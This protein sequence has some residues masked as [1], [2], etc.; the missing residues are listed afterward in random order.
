MSRQITLCILLL[1]FLVPAL[2]Q[3][4]QAASKLDMLIQELQIIV[5]RLEKKEIDEIQNELERLKQNIQLAREIKL[6]VVQSQQVVESRGSELTQKLKEDIRIFY[7][8]LREIPIIRRSDEWGRLES[9]WLNLQSR[10]VDS[11]PESEAALYQQQIK[12]V[13]DELH[14]LELA[15]EK[16][17]SK[18]LQD[19]YQLYLTVSKDNW[20]QQFSRWQAVQSS[21]EKSWEKRE[22]KGLAGAAHFEEIYLALLDLAAKAREQKEKAHK[23]FAAVYGEVQNL[24]TTLVKAAIVTR[25]EKWI[26]YEQKWR[27]IRDADLTLLSPQETRKL[28][29]ELVTLR[30]ALLAYQAEMQQLVTR[31][32][33]SAQGIANNIRHDPWAQAVPSYATTIAQ[34]DAQWLSLLDIP[35][36]KAVEL[37]SLLGGF[38]DMQKNAQ[39]SCKEMQ[40]K[41]ASCKQN[42]EKWTVL[43]EPNSLVKRQARWFQ[44]QSQWQELRHFRLENATPAASAKH[45][46]RLSEIQATLQDLQ[47]ETQK[48]MT[49]LLQKAHNIYQN[50]AQETWNST[51]RQWPELAKEW[52]S[53][54]EWKK[55]LA[56]SEIAGLE[57][58]LQKMQV[59]QNT[60]RQQ[61]E[62]MLKEAH[63]QF[64]E[65]QK[66]FEAIRPI[67]NKEANWLEIKKMWDSLSTEQVET[68]SPEQIQDYFNRS[69]ELRQ[70]LEKASLDLRL[71]CIELLSKTNNLY[72]QCVKEQWISQAAKWSEISQKWL[73][74][75][76]LHAD[77]VL[78]EHGPLLDNVYKQLGQSLSEVQKNK[79]NKMLAV[80]SLLAQLV[81]NHNRLHN[82]L[83]LL[84]NQAG[85][86]AWKANLDKVLQQDYHRATPSDITFYEQ[87]LVKLNLGFPLL[88]EEAESNL[89]AMWN[90]TRKLQE[91]LKQTPWTLHL[92][93]KSNTE[94][95]WENIWANKQ[96][97]SLEDSEALVQMKEQLERC[98]PFWWR[99]LPPQCEMPSGFL[100]DMHE[101]ACEG[102]PS[103]PQ[104][105]NDGSVLC[106]Q[107]LQRE[108]RALQLLDLV[109]GHEHTV[110][111]Y[112]PKHR[113]LA[114]PA[115]APQPHTSLLAFSGRKMGFYDIYHLSY[116][117]NQFP[118]PKPVT[119][120]P[121]YDRQPHWC[122]LADKLSLFF[123]RDNDL[124]YLHDGKEYCLLRTTSLQLAELRDFA[125]CSDG[126]L[127]KVALCAADKAG[128]HNSDVY[129]TTASWEQNA[130]KIDTLRKINE[131][132]GNHFA[133]A[134]SKDGQWLVTY[135][136]HEGGKVA[137]TRIY[138]ETGREKIVSNGGSV[139]MPAGIEIRAKGAELF[140]S[141][142]YVL[143]LLTNKEAKHPVLTLTSLDSLSH[144]WQLTDA[145]QQPLFH[146][147]DHVT[148]SPDR[149]FLA[150][151]Y[152][153]PGEG[154][155]LVIAVVQLP[156]L[157]DR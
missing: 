92:F 8:K 84:K 4:N 19:T 66:L 121:E 120:S 52:Q 17:Y 50:M 31:M 142:A 64:Q 101:V 90:K 157:G 153:K 141:P 58:I 45:Y 109:S 150:W 107:T 144:D 135:L 30:T 105:S 49:E 102:E 154:R 108:Q 62:Y 79:A 91:T 10:A 21:W 137:I 16:Q 73:Y 146:E 54:W 44:A 6:L 140:G 11:I 95:L 131:M 29:S 47:A 119:D 81:V 51:S 72:E 103:L 88:Q 40:N 2:P 100:L 132:P 43:L 147:S 70:L 139:L 80:E 113:W 83:F 41:V 42:I 67:G 82:K 77:D 18:M 87:E 26:A 7:N 25:Q 13:A 37:E 12:N 138:A 117:R 130:W 156:A 127:L 34:W 123:L 114:F 23:S 71:Y 134:W 55:E 129:Y 86:L 15:S 89:Q 133:P 96:T 110:E 148:L 145:A 46:E 20:A 35:L 68:L 152:L 1:C 112:D 151:T 14:A 59:I 32:Y 98:W 116:T 65:L 104:W 118:E 63:V 122:L 39:N 28:E 53:L 74:A 93:K 27:E 124:F 57:N 33:H 56:A 125:V 126:Q 24:Y 36:A 115:W 5:R 99:P 60:V 38:V 149:N 106:F 61:K 48:E 69:K 94:R 143:Y 111:L 97:V 136:E 9:T 75:R 128:D 22:A 155:K 76:P 3:E 85:W 78:A